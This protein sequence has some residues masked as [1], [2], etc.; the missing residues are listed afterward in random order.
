VSMGTVVVSVTAE[1]HGGLGSRNNEEKIKVGMA[2]R[3]RSTKEDEFELGG[4]FVR[5]VKGM[6]N[7]MNTVL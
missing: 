1:K 5:M 6:R 2:N 7:E 3:L 4:V